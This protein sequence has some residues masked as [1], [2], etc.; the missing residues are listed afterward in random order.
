M[1]AQSQHRV[2]C[3]RISRNSRNHHLPIAA[4]MTNFSREVHML[5][6]KILDALSK[7]GLHGMK[8]VFDEVLASGIFAAYYI[9][10][11]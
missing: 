4:A 1:M 11:K 3:L 10:T 5:R 7:L 2:K 8:S 9:I 6:D